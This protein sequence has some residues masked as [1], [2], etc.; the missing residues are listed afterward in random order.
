MGS[1]F[2]VDLDVLQRMTKTL[3]DAGDQ[4]ESALKAMTSS[5]AGQVGTEALNKAAD[6]FQHTWQYGLGQL[7]QV[8]KETTEGVKKAHDAYKHCD[9]GI[10]QAMSKIN[11]Q[12]MGAID[13]A[14]QATTVHGGAK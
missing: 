5:Q 7:Q 14:V 6:S 1:F 4:M 2:Q 3:G 10:E 13:Q 12:A 8:I 9:D 11:S